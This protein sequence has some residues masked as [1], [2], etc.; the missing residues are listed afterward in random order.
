MVE[1]RLAVELYITLL[2]AATA[3]GEEAAD[4]FGG[5]DTS[6]SNSSEVPPLLPPPGTA[7]TA[8]G[9][10]PFA[11]NILDSPDVV[12][13]DDCWTKEEEEEALK[14]EE[15]RG[16]PLSAFWREKFEREARKSWDLFYRRNKGNFFKDRHYLGKVFPELCETDA[17]RD[18]ANEIRLRDLHHSGD[19][20]GPQ[21]A[22]RLG[23]RTLLELGC[24]VG[25]AVF[26]LLEENVGL[27]VIAVDLSPRGIG[28]LKQ[29]PMYTCGRCEALVLDATSDPLPACVLE[30]G[31]VDLVLLQFSLSA[32]APK[33]MAAAARL[34][35][36]ALKPGGKLLVRDY[37]RHDEAQ[38]RF[39]K[40]RRLG[41]NVY[42]R[43]DG[44][45]SYFFSLEDLR[46][47]F[48]SGSTPSQDKETSGVGPHDDDPFGC[49]GS[50]GGG[51]NLIEE[52]LA[53]VRRQYAN[54]RQKVARRR[55]WVHGK[56]RKPSDNVD[57]E[58]R[59]PLEPESQ[60]L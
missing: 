47:L 38:L 15:R 35:D 52:E 28:L 41:D 2:A 17:D 34:V 9:P 1:H 57:P 54:R 6:S 36:K 22:G 46:R 58:R 14:S 40:G 33:D 24:G 42:V 39:A 29:H 30:G 37:G 11:G 49:D 44:T 12:W 25:N 26:P 51:A 5:S 4:I 27:Y 13:M 48:C 21:G 60:H 3:A 18:L 43:Q 32:M 45:T 23:R 19:G 8:D 55:V 56:F 10:V 7:M 31:G 50:S 59:T 16:P 53:F 20:N